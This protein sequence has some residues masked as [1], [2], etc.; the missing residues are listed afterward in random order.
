MGNK[1]SIPNATALEDNKTHTNR[2]EIPS[3]SSN[4]IYVI[5][6][7][8]GTGEWGC[9]CPAWIIKKAGKE[10]TCKHLRALM[11]ILLDAQG[12]VPKRIEEEKK[13]PKSGRKIQVEG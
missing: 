1:L 12:A 11:P 3:E 6:Q 9:S 8:R 10:R 5:A 13:A 7:N 4:R 2:F